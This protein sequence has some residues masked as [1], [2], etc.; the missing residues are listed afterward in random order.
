MNKWQT[1]QSLIATLGLTAATF[2]PLMIA[3]PAQSITTFQ[4]V[5]GHWAQLCVEELARQGILTGYKDGL[6]RPD[7]PMSRD[8]FATVVSVAFAK[9]PTVTT[10]A[11]FFDVPASTRTDN[12]LGSA[13][14]TGFLA[15]FPSGV[16]QPNQPLTRVQALVALANGLQ[17]T[18]TQSFYPTQLN[19]VFDDYSTIP[20]YALNAL[21]AATQKGLVV[22]YPNIKYLRPNEPA[23]RA[24]AASFVC[25]AI[26]NF[27]G[28]ASPVPPQYI[29]TAPNSGGLE[30]EIQTS[31]DG[32]MQAILYYTKQNFVYNNLRLRVI[33]DNQNVL[34][35]PLPV[36][37]VVRSSLGFRVIDLDGDRE[38]EILVD[39][40]TKGGEGCC[41]YSL[42]YR[43]MAGANAYSYTQQAWGPGGY[44]L[45]DFDAD[46]VP[47][48][49]SLD[50]RF[51]VRFGGNYADAAAALQ[52]WQYRQ[53]EM[54]DVTRQFP[55]VVSENASRLWQIYGRR[56]SQGQDVKAVL[57]A[58]LGDM[59]SLG[60]GQQGWGVVQ[61]SYNGSDRSEYLNNLRDFLRNAGYYR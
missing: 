20:A 53:G 40:L 18:T 50:P 8:E 5:R 17:L 7:A 1:S 29:V 11:P 9:V 51:G 45:K 4:D 23:T 42:I 3:T 28:K 16:F 32:R 14:E 2:S 48:F 56:S 43:Y 33:R 57:A 27:S 19:L 13:R 39:F 30:T 59:Y 61:D 47:E 49:E 24:E 34:D 22:N 12:A 25:Q 26:G 15:G 55:N 44:N 54:F 35:T 31:P 36:G 41:S 10:N 60:Q 46:G 58:Y 38:P 37:G 6:F 52:I 21:A